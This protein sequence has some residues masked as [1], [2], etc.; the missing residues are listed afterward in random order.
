REETDDG[1]GALESLDALKTN[2]HVEKPRTIVTRNESPDISFDRSINP[3][4]GC[5]H[6]CIYCFARPSHAWLGL[7]PGLDFETRLLAKP[8]APRLLEAELRHPR[9]R[10]A[11]IAIGTNTDPYQ[12]IER[13][14]R[15]MRGCLE[16][17]SAFNHPVMITTKGAMVTRDIDIL[18]PMAAKRQAMVGISV[19]TLD[20]DLCRTLEPR[21]S[22]PR[23][24]LDAIRR[25]SEAGIPVAVMVAPVIPFVTDHELERILEAAREAGAVAAHYILLRLPYEV[26]DLFAEWLETHVPGKAAHVLSLVAQ[27]RGGK[28]YDATHGRRFTGTGANA[29]LLAQRFKVACKR[30]VF[31]PRDVALDTSRF[32]PPPKAGDQLALF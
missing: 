1:W 18:A 31:G 19:T 8:D 16:V 2:M 12:P 28:L 27:S 20:R 30:L 23:S 11:V 5:E 13:E 17:L 10:P 7:S 4:R 25:L 15:I 26:K 32:Q 14:R 29:D 21:A 3:Y 6:G 9:Y 22:T 24:R